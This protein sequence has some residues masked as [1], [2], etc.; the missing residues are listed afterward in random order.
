M[1]HAQGMMV[2][3]CLKNAMMKKCAVDSNTFNAKSLSQFALKFA[4]EEPITQ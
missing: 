2:E 1:G 4:L 3:D